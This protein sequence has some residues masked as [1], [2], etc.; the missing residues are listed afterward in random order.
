[1]PTRTSGITPRSPRPS[2]RA[3][4]APGP[5]CYVRLLAYAWGEPVAA[6]TCLLGETFTPAQAHALG[7][8]HEMAPPG[9][10][11]TGR[12]DR[13]PDAPGVP[14]TVRVHQAGLQAAVLRDIAELADPLDGKL[15]D[16]MTSPQARHA[17]RRSWKQL[18][19]SP[20]PW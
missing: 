5:G 6:R 9:N 18:K 7:I 4:S 8:A 19:G 1:M 2:I 12:R 17:Y 10:W 15:S 20:A 14:R 3:G 16:G 13:R 11:W